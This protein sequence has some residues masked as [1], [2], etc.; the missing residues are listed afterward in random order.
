MS[1]TAVLAVLAALGIIC[2]LCFFRN[3]A[4]RLPFPPGPKP[5]PV[6]GNLRDLPFKDEAATYNKWAKEHGDLVYANVL[7]RH[8][9]FVN[10]LQIANDLFEKRSVNYSDRNE[11][12]MIND[13][14]GWDWSFGH[15]PYGERWK[16]HRKMFERQFRP[17]VAPT[18][19]P[20]LRKEAHGLIRNI[21]DTPGDLI[22]HLH[23]NAA[24]VIMNVIYG[25]EIAPRGDKYIDIAEEALD[26]MA[27]AA[28]PGAFLVNIF[29]LLKYVPAWVP[30]A[31]FQKK[32]AA[33]KRAALSMRDLP[34]QAVQKALANGTASHCFVSHLMSDSDGKGD[35]DDQIE[36]I[37]GCAGLA[38]AA[39]A[40]STVSSL[41]SFFLAMALHSEVQINA[42]AEL[43]AVIGPGRLPDYKD[44]ASLPYINAT[45]KEVLRWNPVAPLGLPHMV[46]NDDT[47]NGYFIPAGTTIIGNTWTILHDERNYDHPMRFWPERFLTANGTENE[48]ILNPA[49]AAFGYGRRICPGRFMADAQIWIS[50]A[51]ILTVF[52]I[53]PGPDDKGVPVD[54]RAEIQSDMICQP[55]K[56]S[57][58]PRSEGAKAIIRQTADLT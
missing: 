44:R 11:L 55:F 28:A 16:K 40:E 51:C 58:T 17:V 3:K 18:Y 41:S 19:W 54:I 29:P 49:T 15:M 26:G 43:D 35:A 32:A 4:E 27:K 33:W 13:L 23:H 57:V 36:T 53:R 2:T 22:E 42:Q 5:L 8:L 30:G 37:K 47:Y 50:V 9:L 48:T 34:F 20:I 12:P 21:L 56:Y 38:Y 25:I 45:V 24:S 1:S 31:G 52:D 7:G 14:M 6:I 46:T 10:S 39:G